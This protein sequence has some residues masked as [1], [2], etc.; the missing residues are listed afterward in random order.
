MIGSSIASDPRRWRWAL[1]ALFGVIAACVIVAGC[2]RHLNDARPGARSADSVRR[3]GC[4]GGAR[5]TLTGGATAAVLRLTR[6]GATSPMLAG[7]LADPHR[8]GDRLDARVA[9]T[10]VHLEPVGRYG[11]AEHLTIGTLSCWR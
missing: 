5:A 11:L 7:Q 9:G 4:D 8:R 3:F 6:A 1:A 10:S 2:D